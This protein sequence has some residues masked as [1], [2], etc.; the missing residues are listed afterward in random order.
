M[1][2]TC[3]VTSV[4]DDWMGNGTQQSEIT[5]VLVLE[6]VFKQVFVLG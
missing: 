1:F 4:D 2:T 6:S 5:N 3:D